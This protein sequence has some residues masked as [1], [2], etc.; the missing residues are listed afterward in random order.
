MVSLMVLIAAGLLTSSSAVVHLPQSTAD[1]GAGAKLRR[2][3]K[4]HFLAQVSAGILA[5]GSILVAV[6]VQQGAFQ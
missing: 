6:H 5:L 2:R 4:N 1:A 3:F